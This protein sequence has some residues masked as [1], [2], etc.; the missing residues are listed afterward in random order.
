MRR[1]SHLVLLCG[2]VTFSGCDKLDFI[3]AKDEPTPFADA[4]KELTARANVPVVVRPSGGAKEGDKTFKEVVVSFQQ[5][6]S[7]SPAELERFANL[8]VR[9]HVPGVQTVK[10]EYA[11]AGGRPPR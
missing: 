10:F 11:P 7:E 8:V 3:N 6:P 2:L 9:K 4:S 5:P 1:L